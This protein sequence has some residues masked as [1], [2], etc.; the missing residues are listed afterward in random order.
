MSPDGKWIAYKHLHDAYLTAMPL[1]GTGTLELG[2][3]DGSLKVYALTKDMA[4]WLHWQDATTLTWGAANQLHRTTVEHVLAKAKAEKAKEKAEK[5]KAKADK[6]AGKDT[7]ESESEDTEADGSDE[8]QAAPDPFAPATIT[9]TLE[10]PRARPQGT[11]VIDNA[12]LITMSGDEVIENGRLVIEGARI[13][14]VGSV[15]SVEIPVGARVI[16]AQGLT[17][18]PG[19][20]N[21]HAHMGYNSMDVLPQRDWQYYANLAYGVTTTMDPSASTH[22]VFAQSEMVEAG[23]M[24]GPRVYSTG[25]ILYGAD[26]PGRAPTTSYEDALRHVKRMKQYGAFAIK[27]YMQPK[28]VQRQWF[29]KACR[30]LEMLNFPEGGGN[31]ENNMGMILDGH[32]GIEHTTPVAPLYEDILQMWSHT[33][34]GY[35]PTFLVAYGGISGENWFYQHAGPVWADAKLAR[36][37]PRAVIES[38]SR[39]LPGHAYD[40]DYFHMKVAASANALLERGVLVNLGEHG[41]RQGLGAHWD[42]WAL[43]HGGTSNHDV[44][45]AGTIFPATYIGLGSQLGSLE[46]GKLAD[47]VLLGADPLVDIHNTNTVRYTIKNGELFDADTMN[48][49]WPVE[50]QRE[51]FLFEGP[52]AALGTIGTL[53]TQ[54]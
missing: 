18:I 20:V 45:R 17:A 3:S 35:T 16:D 43:S 51:P 49:I 11:L 31:F 52:A 19:L 32:T 15:G 2:D 54:E 39:R 5:D 6:A 28:R 26:I 37:T 4:D 48:Q 13:T 34:V 44:L 42:L 46:A 30:E 24:K 8:P 10:V 29:V 7:V 33:K 27:S 53:G 9:I 50:V 36:F 21:A 1:P 40:G 23:V 22:L 12:R 47:V 38:R 41:Q 14:A 25:F